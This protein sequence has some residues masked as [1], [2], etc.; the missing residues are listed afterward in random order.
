FG[1]LTLNATNDV[2]LTAVGGA[3]DILNTYTLITSTSLSGNQNFFRI[4]GPLAQSRY[5][6]AFDNTSTPN[7][8]KLIVGRRGSANLTWSGD[9]PANVWH[10]VALKWT[11][12]GPNE[13]FSL[14][15]VIFNDT[16]SASPAVSMTGTLIPGTMTV[17]NSAKNFSFAGSGGLAASG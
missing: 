13:F 6:F 8:V 2:N 4:A 10:A 5:T 12:G 16:G 14:D 15:N 11:N 17:N 3:L 7:A 1:S 9:S